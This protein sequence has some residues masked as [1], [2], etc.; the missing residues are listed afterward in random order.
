MVVPS[1]V[2]APW[3]WLRPPS[4]WLP[5]PCMDF[6]GSRDLAFQGLAKAF[7]GLALASQGLAQCSG[8]WMGGWIDVWNFSPFYMTSSTTGTAAQWPLNTTYQVYFPT[9]NPI[10]LNAFT[11]AP[12]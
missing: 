12:I 5:W 10:P 11:M 8:G 3:T 1:Q 9:F 6:S 7:Q 2:Q 4:T